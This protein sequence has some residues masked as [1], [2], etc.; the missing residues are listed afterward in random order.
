MNYT[1]ECIVGIDFGL[2]RVGL[3]ICPKGVLMAIPSETILYDSTDEKTV[4]NIIQTIS[5]TI[6]RFIVGLPKFTDGT[7]STMTKRIREFAVVVEAVSNKPVHLV[8]ETLTSEN[9]E[10]LL[11]EQ[12]M[13]RK[14]RSSHKDSLS[15]QL[16]LKDF[17]DNPTIH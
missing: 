10:T 8:D 11:K 9:S 15:A 12:G 17:I 13:N 14:E 3:A 7:E 2:K 16:I 5:S 6:D 1:D 4:K